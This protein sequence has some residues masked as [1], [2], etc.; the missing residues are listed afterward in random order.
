MSFTPNT[1]AND[2]SL[3]AIDVQKL[4]FSYADEPALHSIDLAIP[5]G[6]RVLCIGANGGAFSKDSSLRRLLSLLSVCRD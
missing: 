2:P 3:L 5:Q 6:S 1:S 4:S